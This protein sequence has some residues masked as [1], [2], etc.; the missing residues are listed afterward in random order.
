MMQEY[1]ESPI[2]TVFGIIMHAVISV[3][4]LGLGGWLL[5]EG[6]RTGEAGFFTGGAVALIS[7]AWPLPIYLRG[8][9]SITVCEDGMVEFR[10]F[11]HCIRVPASGIS[12]VRQTSENDWYVLDR[13]GFLDYQALRMRTVS[14]FGRKSID[15]G[16][17]LVT[18][19]EIT[20]RGGTILLPLVLGIPLRPN[21]ERFDEM[22]ARLRE[23]N[24]DMRIEIPQ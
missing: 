19:I 17:R 8:I 21:I 3:L 24:P 4:T 22:L 7:S 23:M 9:R 5:W 12:A 1:A 14:Y 15:V 16:W 2:R 13:V 20:H 18:F 11:L 10:S 6:F